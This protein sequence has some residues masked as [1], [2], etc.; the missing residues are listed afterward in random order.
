[1]VRSSA[2][3]RHYDVRYD[4]DN[5]R[6]HAR[7]L[8]PDGRIT[9]SIMVQPLGV[10]GVLGE[11]N[12]FSLADIEPAW[13]LTHKLLKPAESGGAG[14]IILRAATY[15]EEIGEVLEH[16]GFRRGASDQTSLYLSSV[17]R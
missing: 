14:L 3:D 6:G 1:M 16:V 17:S 10:Y 9:N 11:F 4:F 13:V 7:I 2:D 12:G 8:S 15:A 5:G